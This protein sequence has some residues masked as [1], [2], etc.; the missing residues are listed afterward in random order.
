MSVEKPHHWMVS[1]HANGHACGT[2]PQFHPSLSAIKSA[3]I[4]RAADA[5]NIVD[6]QVSLHFAPT[7]S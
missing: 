6:I 1:R 5:R 2:V 3:Q 4:E 7:E